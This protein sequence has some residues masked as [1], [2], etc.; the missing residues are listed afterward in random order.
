MRI[1]TKFSSHFSSL[2]SDSLTICGHLNVLCSLRRC[3]GCWV[4]RYCSVVCQ[5]E[6][7]QNS[8]R[9]GCIVYSFKK[10]LSQQTFSL[11]PINGKIFAQYTHGHRRLCKILSGKKRPE[12]PVCTEHQASQ[13]WLQNRNIIIVLRVCGFHLLAFWTD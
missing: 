12:S 2:I 7:W 13:G 9:Y 3:S 6:H 4:V 11:P 10:S 5:K 1:K 8:H